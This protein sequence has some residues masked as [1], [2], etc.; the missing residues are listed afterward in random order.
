M[1]QPARLGPTEWPGGTLG[2]TGDRLCAAD[3]EVHLDDAT[4]IRYAISIETDGL[5][6]YLPRGDLLAP[7][8]VVAS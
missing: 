7:P 3:Q 4:P 2:W 6:T 5:K 1:C 8:S